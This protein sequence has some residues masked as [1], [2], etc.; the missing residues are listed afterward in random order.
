MHHARIYKPAK[1]AMQSGRTLTR[2]WV[3]DLEREKARFHD[4]LMGW[5]GSQDTLHQIRLTF[6]TADDAIAYAK[7][8]GWSYHVQTPRSPLF[9]PKSYADNFAY[10]RIPR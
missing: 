3:L 2:C 8:K 4:P 9:R 7:K 5:T 1:T 6:K 10:D